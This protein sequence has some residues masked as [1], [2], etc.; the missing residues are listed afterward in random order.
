MQNFDEHVMQQKQKRRSQDAVIQDLEDELQ[1]VRASHRQK[2]N[3]HGQLTAEA[4]VCPSTLCTS[5]VC[6]YMRPN[7]RF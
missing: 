6:G 4:K 7:L 1:Q 3:E 5:S 2:V